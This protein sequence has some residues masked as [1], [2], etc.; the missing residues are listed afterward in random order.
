MIVVARPIVLSSS[1]AAAS[2]AYPRIMWQNFARSDSIDATDV[3]VS[4]ETEEGPRDAP[5]LPNTDTFW[6]P[7]SLPATY[8]IDLGVQRD[9]DSCSLIHTL[10]TSRC[11]V[12]PETSPDGSV[13]TALGAETMPA[14]NWPL[15]FLGTLR[16]AKYL[17]L[18]FAGTTAPRIAVIYV[19]KSLAMEMQIVD[20]FAPINF[21]RETVKK[22]SLSRGGQ[23]LGT[24]VRKN[25]VTGS[26]AFKYLTTA[27]VRS[28]FIPFTLSA[29]MGNPY[30]WAWNPLSY[31]ND[32]GYVWTEEDIV[33][34]YSAMRDLMDVGWNM[35]GVG[36]A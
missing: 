7:P 29:A 12:K 30:F 9:I 13:W 5:L 16:S 23:Y 32:V 1:A 4:G 11:S 26:V 34:K 27:W 8:Q 36:E 17:R 22:T 15:V 35:R 6:L 31:P 20:P 33:P 3:T 21:A 19:G 2:L 28:D 18:S 24:G 14:N 25:G 10:G